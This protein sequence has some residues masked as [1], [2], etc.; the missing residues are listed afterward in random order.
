MASLE[1]FLLWVPD[2]LPIIDC[3]HPEH[4]MMTRWNLTLGWASYVSLCLFWWMA[5]GE[6]VN[7][8]SI[9]A[10]WALVCSHAFPFPFVL[11][12]DIGDGLSSN[13]G[14]EAD[15][16]HRVPNRK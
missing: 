7:W 1:Q 5:T 8:S 10:S 4:A 16:I 9:T 13:V 12:F 15:G 11:V 6:D 14:G 3:H 2:K